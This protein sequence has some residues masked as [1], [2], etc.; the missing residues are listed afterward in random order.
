MS[1]YSTVSQYIYVHRL[2]SGSWFE[3]SN[4]QGFSLF[5]YS[6]LFNVQTNLCKLKFT[7]L[8][9]RS[10]LI[11]HYHQTNSCNCFNYYTPY[12]ITIIRM[13]LVMRSQTKHKKHEH[14]N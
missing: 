14:Y 11:K 8:V 6:V 9:K 1:G 4:I 7:G 12:S 3:P 2:H 13:V 5:F 10:G